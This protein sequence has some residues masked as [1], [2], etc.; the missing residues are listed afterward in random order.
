M[1]DAAAGPGSAH[2]FSAVEAPER[3]A[4]TAGP[5]DAEA[6]FVVV[7]YG[8]AG[9]AA[10]IEAAEAGLQVIALDLASGGGSTAIN[11]GI[12]YAG[13]GTAIQKQ[14]GVEDTPEAMFDYLRGDTQGVVS[15]TTLR[16]FCEGSAATLDWLVAHGVRFDPTRYDAK[17]SYPPPGYY[18]YHSD[19]SL[20]AARAARA[21]PAP[22][23]HKVWT[24]GASRGALGF[25]KG[26]TEPLAAA[27]ATLGVRFEPCSEVRRLVQDAAGRVVG[28]VAL[29]FTDPALRARY[30]RLQAAATKFA[31]ALPPAFPGAGLTQALA[32]WYRRRAQALERHR[33]ERRVRARR[34]V[35]LSAGGFVFNPAMVAH[36]APKYAGGMP[37]GNPGDDGSGIRLGQSVG[38]AA[39]R[40]SHMS[41][42]RFIRPPAG[43]SWGP[44]VDGRG[45]RFVDE[46]VYG[47]AIGYEMIE[48]H[49]GRAF[50]VL[51]QPLYEETLRQVRGKDL[52]SFQSGPALLALKFARR[53]AATLEEL[54]ARCGF[55]STAFL[56]TIV[57]YNRAAAGEAADA[58]GKARDDLRPIATGPFYAI[59]VS[60]SSKLFPLPVLSLGG[61]VVDEDSGAVLDGAGRAIAGLYAAGR[62]AVGVC[63]HLYVSGLS[64][65]D[66]IFSGRRAAAAAARKG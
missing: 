16:R 52:Y 21:R 38:G 27:A 40:L 59:D 45:V 6:D 13:G 61:L 64:V 11:G 48:R 56:E 39:Q 54:A 49:G 17:T 7:G 58:F 14:A 60:V 30:A 36:Y 15:D 8:G 33:V 18:L 55:E 63:S 43:L 12:F 23:G 26:F 50:I 9:M 47:A 1:N 31:I 46:T 53:K 5:W 25:G 42:W 22:R 3:V 28:V 34:G 2:W 10:A 4:A 20:A 65:A 57:A 51:D 19:S 44:M 41:A 35:C 66:C 37:L 24:P 29:Q 32:G 62:N